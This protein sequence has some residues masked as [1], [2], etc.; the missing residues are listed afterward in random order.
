VTVN[1]DG[2]VDGM[3]TV[4]IENARPLSEIESASVKEAAKWIGQIRDAIHYLHGKDL[5]WG[6]ARASNVLVNVD[7]DAI[8]VDFG[9]ILRMDG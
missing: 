9:S 5:I 4:W 8:L 2:K 3:L 7:G 6:D 1:A